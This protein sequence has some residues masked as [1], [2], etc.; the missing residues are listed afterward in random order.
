MDIRM[1]GPDEDET[2]ARHYLKIWASYGLGRAISSRRPSPRVLSFMD[3]GREDRKL[4]SFLATSDGE[5]VGSAPC[6]LHQSPFPE[7]IKPEHRLHGSIWTVF[8]ADAHRRRDCKDRDTEGRQLSEIHRLQSR[9][10]CSI[11][12]RSVCWSLLVV[13]ALYIVFQDTTFPN[14]T[15]FLDHHCFRRRPPSVT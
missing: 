13:V 12:H 15:T 6:Q 5:I 2:I 10:F 4:V 3:E 9:G 1:V 7:V 14:P 8:V 11:L